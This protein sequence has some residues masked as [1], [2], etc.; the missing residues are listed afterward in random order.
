MDITIASAAERLG[1]SVP[2][3][4]RA[5]ERLE[6][7]TSKAIVERGRPPRALTEEGFRRLRDELGVTPQGSS[8]RREVWLVLAA[9]TMNPFGFRSRRAVAD[10]ARISPTTASL[11]VDELIDEGVVRAVPRLLR[12]GGRVLE[13]AILELD[14]ES[15][16]RDE[17]LAGVLATRLPAPRAVSEPK[18]VPRRFWHLFWNASPA[19]LPL[20]EYADFIASRMLLSED[21][22]AIS[23]A[24][25]HLPASSIEKT[26][27]LRQV[28]DYERNW[29]RNLA[30]AR[31]ASAIA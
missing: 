19:Q 26:A 20:R 24:A 29:L 21:P 30:R 6:I 8:R 2:R 23:W 22:L 5:I 10:A 13:G 7:P 11:I 15:K 12:H 16:Q 4:T 25:A 9:F 14:P 27:S 1:T 17:I 31:R 3:V 28:N 18:I